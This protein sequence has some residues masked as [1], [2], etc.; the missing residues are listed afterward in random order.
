[1]T[2]LLR[3]YSIIQTPHVAEKDAQNQRTLT[4]VKFLQL[5]T[6]IYAINSPPSMPCPD[7]SKVNS[8][9]NENLQEEEK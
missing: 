7:F 1:M 3:A 2:H 6:S 5:L 8:V 4:A 9:L